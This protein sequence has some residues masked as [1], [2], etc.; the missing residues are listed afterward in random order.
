MAYIRKD[1]DDTK[2]LLGREPLLLNG[3][4]KL[5]T[6]EL[7][8]A[9]GMA[10]PPATEV[11]PKDGIPSTLASFVKANNDRDADSVT[12]CFS[13]DAVVYDDG[14]I[15][16]GAEEIRQWIAELFRK[17]QYVVAPTNVRELTNGA[18]LTAT[19][20]GNFPGARVSLDHNCRTLGDKI[21]VMVLQPTPLPCVATGS[22]NQRRSICGGCARIATFLRSCG[23]GEGGPGDSRSGPERPTLY[24]GIERVRGIGGSNARLALCVRIAFRAGC[25]EGRARSLLR[26]L[27]AF[28]PIGTAVRDGRGQCRRRRAGGRRTASVHLPPADVLAHS[29]RQSGCITAT[30]GRSQTRG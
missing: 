15:M 5:H 21:E 27:Q 25:S 9:A 7:L 30:R 3:W 12:A 24:P 20:T 10:A 13:K 1:E 18:I 14:Q 16:R 2:K 26:S 22:G 8:E 4:A 11:A 28:P 6:N 23:S 29:S 19:I 17:F